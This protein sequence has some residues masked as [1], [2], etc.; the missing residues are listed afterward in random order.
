L[1]SGLGRFDG[2][3]ASY[4]RNELYDVFVVTAN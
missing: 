1:D 4:V 3:P 2:V